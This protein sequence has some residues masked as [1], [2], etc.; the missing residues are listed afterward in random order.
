MRSMIA[1]LGLI[2]LTGCMTTP[3]GQPGTGE[4]LMACN[5]APL[6]QFVGQPASQEL[7]GRM[8]SA[9]GARMI[10]WVPKGGVVTMDFRGDRLT[11]GL[12]DAN[13]VETARC[14]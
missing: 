14:G 9:S 2:P 10:R 7:G 13:R 1:V 6:D 4:P 11:I 3:P 5:N 12:D 8:L